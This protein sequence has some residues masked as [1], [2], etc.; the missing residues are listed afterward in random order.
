[1]NYLY[2]FSINFINLSLGIHA[3][4]FD[5]DEQFFEVYEENE[6][7]KASVKVLVSLEKQERMLVLYFDIKGSVNVMC[8]RCL[9]QFEQ[10]VTGEARLIVKFGDSYSEESDEVV[11]IPE[12][13]YKLNVSQYIYEFIN[14]F[15]PIKRVHL[16]DEQG[17]SKCNPEIVNRLK[18]PEDDED[19]D[20]RWNVLKLLQ[21]S[22]SE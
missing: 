11:V 10:P 15:L 16:D 20:P 18:S 2:Q 8:D 6:I 22:D 3:F 14:L 13:E 5:L 12:S 4:E 21:K 19:T 7:S 1:M 9:D 17:M